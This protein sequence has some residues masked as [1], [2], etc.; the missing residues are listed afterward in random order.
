M[1]LPQWAPPARILATVATKPIIKDPQAVH[2]KWDR[3]GNVCLRVP[4]MPDIE[5]IKFVTAYGGPS[6][7]TLDV[8]HLAPLLRGDCTF[9]GFVD[10]WISP[11]WKMDFELV[12]EEHPGPDPIYRETTPDWA[13]GILNEQAVRQSLLAEGELAVDVD[14]PTG[15]GRVV[16]NYFVSGH[17]TDGTDADEFVSKDNVIYV[18]GREV[19][20]FKPWR[21]DCRRFRTVNP[22]CRRWSDGSW[23]ADYSRSGWCPSD[24]V[25]PVEIDLTR[26]L[27]PG[28]HV[29]RFD[30][31]NV[32]PEDENGHYGYWRVSS[33][34]LGWLAS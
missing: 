30:I 4:G 8:T 20:R 19:R 11:G 21:N 27:A 13:Y 22:Y 33:H 7:H 34:L 18:D 28:K 26:Y 5:V 6:E 3:A 1:R 9:A 24:Q 15:M 17:C 14:I 29:I 12:F 2:D 23:S 32:R 25:R 31:E 10:T 16:M